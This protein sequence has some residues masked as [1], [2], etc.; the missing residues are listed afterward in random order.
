MFTNKENLECLVALNQI[1]D[2][3]LNE[4]IMADELTTESIQ[5]HIEDM[6]SLNRMR[7]RTISD[8]YG[9]LKEKS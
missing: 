9:N 1:A 2:R 3:Q 7:W 4:L 8:L 6:K 5:D